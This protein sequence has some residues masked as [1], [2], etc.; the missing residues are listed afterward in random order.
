MTKT[1]IYTHDSIL[2]KVKYLK[3]IKIIEWGK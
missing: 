3:N 1:Y 2:L